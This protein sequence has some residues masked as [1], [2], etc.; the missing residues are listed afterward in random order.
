MSRL[1]STASKVGVATVAAAA[2]PVMFG[3]AAYAGAAHANSGAVIETLSG[4]AITTPQG[5]NTE[6][7]IILPT[8]ASCSGNT[9][10]DGYNVSSYIADNGLEANPGVFT[11]Q[12]GVPTEA[13]ANNLITGGS[14]G[15]AYAGE[16]TTSTGGVIPP[17][18][19]EFGNNYGPF[20]PNATSTNNQSG[21]FLYPGT[22]NIG[23]ACTNPSSGAATTDQYWPL[24]VTLTADSSD[25]NGYQWAPVSGAS[26]PEVPFA[27][28]L[29]LSAVGI[30]GAGFLIARRRRSRTVT[31]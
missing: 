31:A 16:T 1:R 30:A 9:N 11:Y 23:I 25:P 28:I 7:Q 2:I 3:T 8:G 29:P 15:G 24:Q 4:Q 21:D 14:S 17:A 19:L 20:D 5:S 10:P 18:S 12:D 27:V 13:D 22:F 26:T 6:F